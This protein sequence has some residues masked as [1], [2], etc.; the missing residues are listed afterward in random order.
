MGWFDIPE[1]KI[2]YVPTL[3]PMGAV[4]FAIAC[5]HC[6]HYNERSSERCGRCIMEIESGFE[7]GP[8]RGISIDET[9]CCHNCPHY[10]AYM[11]AKQGRGLCD[12]FM[13]EMPEDGYCSE[14]GKGDKGGE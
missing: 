1:K 13:H 10:H 6:R 7:L 4:T 5:D 14:H 12:H 9:K 8:Y 3:Y 2:I 11:N